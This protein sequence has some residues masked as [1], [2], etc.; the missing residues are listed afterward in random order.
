[1]DPRIKNERLKAAAIHAVLSLVSAMVISAVVFKLW[2]PTPLSDITGSATLYWMVIAVD[3]ICGPLILLV[4]W[5]PKKPRRELITDAAIVVTIQLAALAYGVWT[6]SQIRPV[7]IVFET[8][9]LRMVNAAEIDPVDLASAPA[10][11]GHLPLLGP[12]L[13]S[14]R[15]P[16]DGDEM[17]RSIELS[18]AGKEPSVRPEMWEEYAP[19][20]EKIRKAARSLPELTSVYPDK[21]AEITRLAEKF[22][23]PYAS[24]VWLPFTSVRSM[25]WVALMDAR[26]MKPFTYIPGDGFIPRQ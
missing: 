18:I 20:Q 8:D 4:I 19:A 24:V 25:D 23:V 10:Q 12:Q 11:W 17:L 5:N 15:V 6:I 14:T 21:Q 16:T 3:I 2:F 1:M 26:N 9:R 22:D 13:L 7:Y